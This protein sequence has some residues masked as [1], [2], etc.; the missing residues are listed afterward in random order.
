MSRELLGIK[1]KF[2]MNWRVKV[3]GKAVK[4]ENM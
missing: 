3:T 4:Q 2:I 1:I